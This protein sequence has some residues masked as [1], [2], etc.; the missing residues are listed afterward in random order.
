MKLFK[1]FGGGYA[2]LSVDPLSAPADDAL[3]ITPDDTT[4]YSPPL[5]A[6]RFA[7]AGDVTI[8][9]VGSDTL[10]FIPGVLAG[11]TISVRCRKVM[12]TDTSF[13]AGVI[14]GFI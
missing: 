12:E 11:E 8:L 13:G 3:P 10:R 1:L 4:V 9:T 5:K 7:E 6:L 2:D 14:T